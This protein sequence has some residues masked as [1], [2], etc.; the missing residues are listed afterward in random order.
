SLKL[1]SF[2]VNNTQS[3]QF[4][5]MP[6][7]NRFATLISTKRANFSGALSWAMEG[8]P[9]GVKLLAEPMAA[10]LDSMPLVFEAAADAPIAGKLT[11]LTATGTNGTT[12]IV[13][14]FRQEVE[15]VQGPP[16][17]AVYYSTSVDK[18]C[19]AVTKETPFN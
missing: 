17:S 2:T 16:N 9:P 3:R 13:G 10:N 4:I 11:D 12:S 19:V 18:L 6:P 15:L 7:G 8:L 14:K 1:P 5:P